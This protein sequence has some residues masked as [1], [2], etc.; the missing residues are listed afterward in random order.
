[1]AKKV[2]EVVEE[3]L[4]K[5][6]SRSDLMKKMEKNFGQGTVVGLNSQPQFHEFISTG[7]IG[8]DKALGIGGLPRGR[9]IEI[10]GPES[11]GKT[12]IAMHV[13]KEAQKLAKDSLCAIVDVEHA[14]SRDYATKMGIDID[15][16][17][18]SQPDYGEQA[19]EITRQLVESGLYDVV[20]IDSVAGLVPKSELE[21]EIGDA[22]MGK[23]A[24]MMSQALR[25]LVGVASK[26]NTMLIFINQLRDKIG[27]YGNPEATT[28][29]NALKFYASVR[30]DIRRRFDKDNSIMDG[31]IKV[32]N[33]TKVKVIK[34]KV[35]PPFRECEFNI[36]FGEGVDRFGEI[37][38]IAVDT[39]V[40]SKSGSWYSYNGTKIG[41]GFESVRQFMKDN[42]ELF[43][44]I[45]KKV[46]DTFTPR[47]FVPTKEDIE[48]NK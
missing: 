15:R 48:S 7:S 16:V 17:D 30:L 11:S 14:F 35:S 42:E 45:K 25:M 1:M 10:Y 38:A 37:V 13:M 22:Q 19:L 41:Q 6:E 46:E 9:V 8:L 39:G 28:G 4:S 21:G 36:I 20:V 3:T 27:G 44:E 47:E 43:E 12:T 31:D 34:N 26:T 32:G 5:T 18:I 2:I 40:I 23:Q 33:L 29:G 24:R